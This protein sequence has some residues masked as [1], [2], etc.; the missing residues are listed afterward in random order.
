[1]YSKDTIRLNLM[2]SLWIYIPFIVYTMANLMFRTMSCLCRHSAPTFFCFRYY[3]H[4]CRHQCPWQNQ[5]SAASCKVI[6]M[7]TGPITRER[8][9]AVSLWHLPQR[10][11]NSLHYATAPCHSQPQFSKA[12]VWLLSSKVQ[13]DR[14][15][16]LSHARCAWCCLAARPEGPSEMS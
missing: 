11:F 4:T 8:R 3:S 15:P 7:A 14:Q 10:L 1:M 2:H 13:L 9:S 12:P 5:H 16:A 6:A